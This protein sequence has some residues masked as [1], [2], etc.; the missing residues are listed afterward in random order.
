[1]GGACSV[2]HKQ[3]VPCESSVW[4]DSFEPLQ[5]TVKHKQRVLLRKQS[6]LCLCFT[7]VWR[8]SEES[9]N[10][11]LAWYTLLMLYSSSKRFRRVEP[12]LGGECERLALQPGVGAGL[13][14][15]H[16]YNVTSFW[17]SVIVNFMSAN[18]IVR[19]CKQL[20]FSQSD[21]DICSVL[22]HCLFQYISKSFF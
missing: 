7:V 15:C 20:H 18:R 14:Q 8:G 22:S 4:F 9:T 1:M 21:C 16:C 2:Q 17:L 13:L 3:R 6:T 19:Y 5:T 11:T 10:R 12:L